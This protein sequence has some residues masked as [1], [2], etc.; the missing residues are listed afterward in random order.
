[1]E[2]S[3]TLSLD[4]Q[5]NH[6]LHVIT[7]YLCFPTKLYHNGN[8]IQ[9]CTAQLINCSEYHREAK[10]LVDRPSTGSFPALLQEKC[11]RE[12]CLLWWKLHRACS[13]TGSRHG[14]SCYT[15]KNQYR[16]FETNNP[17][18]GIARPQSFFQMHVPL[19]DLQSP[20]IDL[21][22]YV[23]RSWKYIFRSQT[24]ECGNLGLRPRN[25]QKRNT[26]MGF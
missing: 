6:L 5:N 13:G 11:R 2:S 12:A 7:D 26:Q 9:F 18:T 24:H 3:E 19:S 15:A 17:R 8:Y 22:I 4:C 16:K 10:R 23:D 25:S 20:P 14:F 21:P 1:M